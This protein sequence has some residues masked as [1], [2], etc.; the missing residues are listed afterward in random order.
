MDAIGEQVHWDLKYPSLADAE[1]TINELAAVT[2]KMMVTEMDIDVLPAPDP[3][4][5]GNAEVRSHLRV[6]EGIRSVHQGSHGGGAAEAG[7]PLCRAISAISQTSGRDQAR[8]VV[9]HGRRHVA[10]STPGR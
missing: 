3:E 9:G 10:G 1:T 6:A 2:G 5:T 4:L 7:R 8:D